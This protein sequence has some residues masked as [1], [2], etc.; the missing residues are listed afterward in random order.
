MSGTIIKSSVF[1]K[2]SLRREFFSAAIP[3]DKWEIHAEHDEKSDTGK[4][5]EI[6]SMS[7]ACPLRQN[8]E[9]RTGRRQL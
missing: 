8:H 6:N 9:R 2:L 5:Q 1:E 7:A 3:L 4:Q